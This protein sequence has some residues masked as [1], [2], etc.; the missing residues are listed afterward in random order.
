MALYKY[1]Y[2]E[3]DTKRSPRI[4]LQNIVAGETGNRIW[5]T[6]TNNG[7]VIDM[8][9]KED[10]EFIYR[11][12]LRIDS[13]LGTRR[14]DSDDPDGGITFIEANTGDHGKINIL[15]SADSFTAGKNRCRLEIYSKRSEDD[16]TLICSAEWTFDAAGNPT[17]E[18]VGTAYPLMAYYEQLAKSWAVGGTGR[19]DG[20]DADNAKFYAQIAQDLFDH[21][22]VEPSVFAWLTANLD[23]FKTLISADIVAWLAANITN[24]TYP[25]IDASLLF[26]GSAADAHS[27]GEIR[28]AV[29]DSTK[30][31]SERMS[32]WMQGRINTTTGTVPSSDYYCRTTNP[33]AFPQSGLLT[34]IVPT[35]YKLDCNEYNGSPT[36][37]G[38][39]ER[40]VF[41][42]MTGSITVYVDAS[43]YYRFALGKS[44]GTELLLANLPAT[45]FTYTLHVV[46]DE[47][48]DNMLVG[49]FSENDLETGRYNVATAAEGTSGTTVKDRCGATYTVLGLRSPLQKHRGFIDNVDRIVSRG[50]NIY[51]YVIGVEADGTVK[52]C[53]CDGTWTTS[54]TLIVK[55]VNIKALR[56]QGI[57]VKLCVVD[58]STSSQIS[59][60]SVIDYIDV[61][62]TPAQKSDS[63]PSYYKSMLATAKANAL[64]KM[65]SVGRNGFT[66][67][68]FTDPHWSNNAKQTPSLMKHVKDSLGISDVI[69]GG[70]II[71]GQGTVEYAESE[72]LGCLSAFRKVGITFPVA[73]GNHDGNWNTDGGQREHPDRQLSEKAVYALMEQ[74]YD[75]HTPV[76]FT[77]S[78]FNFYVDYPK[79][80]TRVIFLDT[81]DTREVDGST[82]IFYTDYV[83]YADALTDS[84]NKNII[85]IAHAV[86]TNS[87]GT[88]LCRIANSYNARQ[89]HD[90]SY[91]TY[92][93]THAQGHVYV[94]MG[95]HGHDD[96][97]VTPTAGGISYVMTDTDSLGTHNTDGAT[98]GTPTEQAFD[99][100]TVNYNTGTTYMTRVGRGDD[101]QI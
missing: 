94:V 15:L 97:I 42:S 27:A 93:F 65:E 22:V 34:I 44:D 11:V 70:D 100:V 98:P 12:S 84:G 24:P 28:A 41:V 77:D 29:V 26:K 58:I 95:G 10:D 38:N 57:S 8:S 78:G 68:F 43:K 39:F 72:L 13:D 96:K 56:N 35:G 61:Y 7:D 79:S 66:F 48:L 59:A 64:A 55:D 50:A 92:D 75:K 51:F 23:T 89:V 74:G 2:I 21:Q 73:Y 32:K 6:V 82:G 63:V 88:R 80:N 19:R 81:G 25:P 90:T 9:A 1:H 67:M 49:K 46:S 16:D 53:Y 36:S 85:V 83:D 4:S 14:Q 18:N 31:L 76:Y 60:A 20:E 71:A 30:P 87:I 3:L 52:G 47:L 37:S 54:D 101:R 5:I 62:Y 45:P 86:Y 40:N 99:I 91:L 33:Y 17:G 69:C